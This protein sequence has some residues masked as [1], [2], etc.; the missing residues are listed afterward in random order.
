MHPEEE[1][2]DGEVL[3]KDLNDVLNTL[4]W[5]ERNVLSM[6]FGLVSSDG[7]SMTRL[8]VGGTYNISAERVRQIEDVAMRKLRSP[9]RCVTLARH[10]NG[11]VAL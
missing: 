2:Y 4:D 10:L 1:Y 3:Q 8:D 7:D 5:R 11:D 6:H 9:N